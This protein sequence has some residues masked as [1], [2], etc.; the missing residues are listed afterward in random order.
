MRVFTLLF[1]DRIPME[2]MSSKFLSLVTLR[3]SEAQATQRFCTAPGRATQEVTLG[4]LGRSS[5]YDVANVTGTSHWGPGGA[6]LE[7]QQATKKHRWWITGIG[8]EDPASPLRDTVQ[9][10]GVSAE[11]VSTHNPPRPVSHQPLAIK[12]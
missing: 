9:S 3:F 2:E 12:C 8:S 4:P 5:S 1:L 6:E 7:N 10:S 11:G